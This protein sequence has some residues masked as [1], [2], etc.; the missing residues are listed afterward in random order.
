MSPL[1]VPP[2]FRSTSLDR[3]GFLRLGGSA[4]LVVGTTALLAACTD[5]SAGT[6]AATGGA[7]SGGSFG[8]IAVQ[9]SW[10]KN[11]EFAGEYFATEKGY[12][13]DAGFSEVTLLAGGGQT[14]AEEALLAG[15]AKVGLSSA[16][17]TGPS[18]AQ[19]AALKIIG[20]TF[21][22]N[23]FCL[24]S[25][26]E[27]E[28]IRTLADLKGK[29]IGVQSGGNQT[30]FE[31][32]LKANDM[33]LDDV[34]LVATQ[35]DIAPLETNAYDAH[36][37]Y[38]TNEPILAEMDGFTPVVLGFADNG[39]PFVAETFTVTQDTIDNERDM[40]K[41]FLVAEIKGWTDAVKDPEQ[42]AKYAAEKY[43][44]D[45]DLD[46]EEQTAEAEAQNTLILTEDVNANGLFTMTD[47][48]VA[49]NIA[50]LKAMGTDVSADDLFDLSIIKEVYEENPDLV[51]TF[52]IPTA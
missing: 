44:K 29:K 17:L 20:T 42:S 48:L 13:T 43:G 6:G 35:Y 15:Q 10:I 33:T 37:S 27:G 5:S 22:K 45:Q 52:E 8:T 19:G 9:L 31:G 32:F 1:S 3:R 36:M 51:T 38:I 46:V 40:L 50:S 41:A 2:A 39:L 25:L 14:G 47:E 16:S 18:V 12:Y 30:I 34:E 28:P 4:A 49:E 23:P 24:L 11:I 21:Q 7:A 26:E